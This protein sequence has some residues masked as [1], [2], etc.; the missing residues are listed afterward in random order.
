MMKRLS[1]L[2]RVA[3]VLS[4]CKSNAEEARVFHAKRLE[5]LGAD[6]VFEWLFG[7]DFSDSRR[8]VEAHRAVVK[9]R[10]WLGCQTG[11]CQRLAPIPAASDSGVT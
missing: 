10:A 11:L 7:R 4:A 2:G 6:E 8:D 9:F 1:P 5:E 3:R